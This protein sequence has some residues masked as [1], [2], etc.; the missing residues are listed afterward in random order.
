ML[1]LGTIFNAVSKLI[2]WFNIGFKCSG[3]A[4]IGYSRRR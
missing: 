4:M 1:Y 2:I 3:Y